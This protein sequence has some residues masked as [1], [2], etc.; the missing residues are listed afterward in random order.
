LPGLT[1]AQHG[2]LFQT[3]VA[4]LS[5]RVGAAMPSA[6]DEIH[7]FFT[8]TLTLD[9]KDFRSATFGADLAIRVSS[10]ADVVLG[11]SHASIKR[12]SH[13]ENWTHQDD[14]EIEQTTMLR[15]TPVTLGGRV[16]LMDRGRSVGSFAWVPTTFAPY[17][18]GAM[19]FTWYTLEQEGEFV[20]NTNL[21]IFAATLHSSGKSEQLHVFGGA[22]WWASSRVGFTAEARYSWGSAPLN[23]NFTAFRDID[24]RG[25]QLTA[26]LATRF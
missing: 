5:V 13:F 10:R 16:F 26:G 21:D 9:P 24:L 15:R 22:E 7:R 8:D 3:P 14:R 23:E 1:P 2:Y 25:F 6:S 11:V 12:A 4:T 19:G 18:G 17:V 20:D